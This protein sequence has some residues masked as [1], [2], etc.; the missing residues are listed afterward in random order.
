MTMGLPDFTVEHLKKLPLR[1]IVAFAARCAR[2]VEPIAQ[3]PEG[4]PGREGRRAAV[5]AAL[6]LAEGF[7][8]GQACPAADSVVQAVDVSRGAAGVARSCESAAAAAAETAHAAAAAWHA[9]GRVERD[10]SRNLWEGTA[11]SQNVRGLLKHTTVELAALNAFTAAAEAYEA[12]GLHNKGY[13]TAALNDY[14]KLLLLNLGLYPEPG[15]PIDP[16]PAGPLGLL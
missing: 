13:V 16:S 15:D 6:R 1:A 7:S 3:L 5:D 11:G 9:F 2:R 12:V 10:R 14:D 8:M 4:H